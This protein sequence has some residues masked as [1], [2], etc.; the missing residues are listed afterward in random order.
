[1]NN[2]L[3]LQRKSQTIDKVKTK[4]KGINWDFTN[5]LLAKDY[6]CY[7]FYNEKEVMAYITII[8]SELVDMYQVSQARGT[9]IEKTTGLTKSKINR[10]NR[11]LM[12]YTDAEVLSSL[13]YL[14]EGVK[15]SM[16]G[17]LHLNIMFKSFMAYLLSN[18]FK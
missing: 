2:L 11:R 6:K 5:L 4:R 12:F 3:N 9:D 1:M 7:N 17:K 10:A 13:T 14:Y 18:W 8:T 16:V 15:L